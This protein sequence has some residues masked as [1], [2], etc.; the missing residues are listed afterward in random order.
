[1]TKPKYCAKCGKE[2]NPE[3]YDSYSSMGEATYGI[4]DN[5]LICKPKCQDAWDRHI[6]DNLKPKNKSWYHD[7]VKHFERWIGYVWK[8]KSLKALEKVVFT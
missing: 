6:R 5:P 4:V 7:W 8:G 1:M 3:D 2:I